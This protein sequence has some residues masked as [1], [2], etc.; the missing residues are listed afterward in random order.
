MYSVEEFDQQKTKIMNYI[1]YK[2]RTEKEVKNK[3][4][5]TC[6]EELLCDIISYVKEAGYLSDKEYIER[7]VREFMALKS[8]SIKEMKYKLYAKGIHKEDLENYFYENKEELIEYEEKSAEKIL[9]KKQSTMEK[10]EIENYLRKKGYK[11][12][13]IKEVIICKT[14]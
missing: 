5:N 10:E 1:L 4:Q 3:F 2:K 11:E 9:I 12:E 6:A 8:L 14:Y 13:T 7:S